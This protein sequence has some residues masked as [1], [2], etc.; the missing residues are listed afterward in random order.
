MSEQHSKT[1]SR[2]LC[3][4]KLGTGH[5]IKS[6]TIGSFLERFVVKIANDLLC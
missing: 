5:Y 6:F 4:E 1:T 3:C 2:K